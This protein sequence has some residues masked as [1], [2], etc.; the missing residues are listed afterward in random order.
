M[1]QNKIFWTIYFEIHCR[2]YPW[3]IPWVTRCEFVYRFMIRGINH[4]HNE[5]YQIFN[6]S[7]FESQMK[8]GMKGNW[9]LTTK[10]YHYL[11][12]FVTI[13]NDNMYIYCTIKSFLGNCFRDPSAEILNFVNKFFNVILEWNS[14][15]TIPAS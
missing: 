8:K 4:L 11:V 2:T 1:L 10:F 14:N 9:T 7:I 3:V 15:W 13:A 5:V 6:L 12:S